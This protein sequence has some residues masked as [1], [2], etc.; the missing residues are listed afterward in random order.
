VLFLGTLVTGSGPHSGDA[1]EPAR[2]GFDPR[3]ISW[4]H[5][6]VVMLFVG[7]VVATWLTAR[8]TS[9]DADRAP[10]RAWFAV[11]AVSLAQ[12]VIG[13][14]Q[15]FANL[16]EALVIAHMLGATLLVV[17]LTNGILALRRR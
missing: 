13:Y 12:G 8:L 14:V 9:K 16:P 6:D 17:A 15:Y 2:L 11:L 1:D 4:L 3:T 7:L 10:G 5:A